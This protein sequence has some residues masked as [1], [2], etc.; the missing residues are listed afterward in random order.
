MYVHSKFTD[1][2]PRCYMISAVQRAV[3]QGMNHE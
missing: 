2:A 1:A 3:K